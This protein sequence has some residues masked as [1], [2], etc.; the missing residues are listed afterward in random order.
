MPP[1]GAGTTASA[2]SP[3]GSDQ[4]APTRLSFL[5]Q[6][7]QPPKLPDPVSEICHQLQQLGIRWE[8]PWEFG[9]TVV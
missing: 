4:G 3:S 1:R 6:V 2:V 8:P 5:V 7:V 9:G